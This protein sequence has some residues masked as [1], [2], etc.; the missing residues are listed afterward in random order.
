M[1]WTAGPGRARAHQLVMA[2]LSSSTTDASGVDGVRLSDAAA[3]YEGSHLWCDSARRGC[4]VPRF[5][6]RGDVVWSLER[7]PREEWL[8]RELYVV[9]GT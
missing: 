4:G 3:A 8:R 9:A 1:L 7:A 2:R 5:E 6:S